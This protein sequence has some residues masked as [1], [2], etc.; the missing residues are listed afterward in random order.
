MLE[1]LSVCHAGLTE[2]SRLGRC[3]GVRQRVGFSLLVETYVFTIVAI[4]LAKEPEVNVT[5][6]RVQG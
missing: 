5:F 1:S 4:A 6:A 2:A 3:A